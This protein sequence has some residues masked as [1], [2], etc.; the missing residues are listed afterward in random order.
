MGRK[1][2]KLFFIYALGLF[3]VFLHNGS[4]LAD[5]SSQK[6]AQQFYDQAV[7]ARENGDLQKAREACQKIL[8]DYPD[9]E[10]LP[11]VRKQLQEILLALI[12]SDQNSPETLEYIVQ[13]GDTLGSIARAKKTTLELLK[14][15]NHL[16]SDTIRPGQRLSLWN[17]P[18]EI[19]ID[20]THNTLQLKTANQ[21]V[22][23]YPVATGKQQTTTP[24]GEFTIQ[25]RYPNPVWFHH[26]EIVPPGSPENFLGTRWLGFN[27]PKYGIHGTIQPE[28]IGQSVSGGCVRMRNEDV[29]ELYDL[30]PVGT[31]VTIVE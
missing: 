4:T 8:T 30:V 27:K 25:H 29:E 11:A 21:I 9:Y 26:G 10:F 14:G 3:M 28:L 19:L 12:V 20:K 13:P 17:S 6:P 22:K 18:F 1:S 23:T 2:L 15:R 5:I 31:K 7:L 24:L 16:T